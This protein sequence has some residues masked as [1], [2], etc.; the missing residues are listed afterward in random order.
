MMRYV[1]RIV[2]CVVCVASVGSLGGSLEALFELAV[3]CLKRYEM[4]DPSLLGKDELVGVVDSVVAV[5]LVVR[6]ERVSASSD[7][8]C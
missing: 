3:H 2:A 6:K 1:E 5:L 8:L 7:I 4:R